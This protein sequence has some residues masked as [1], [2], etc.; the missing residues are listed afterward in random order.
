MPTNTPLSRSLE[1]HQ[2]SFKE[3]PVID[4]ASLVDDSN[5]ESVA[6][7]IGE[8]CE[9]VRFLY[10][11][12]HGISQYF[13]DEAYKQSAAFFDLPTEK[14]EQLHIR[15]SGETLRGYIPIYGENVD[16]GYTRDFKECF[17][18]GVGENFVSPFFGPILMPTIHP[19]FQST[20][21]NYHQA[22]LDLGRKQVRAIS[23][24]LNLPANN[25]ES[26]QRHPITIQRLLH[27]PPQS[28]EI[29]S[30]SSV[31]EHIPITVF[32]DN[33]GSGQ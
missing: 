4:V 25:F 18:L 1:S 32:F 13:I 16:P 5:P 20:L 3:I 15:N 6:R 33:L 7:I 14:K 2:T 26:R 11:K 28:S 24:S 17:D 31:S 8:T 21:E 19:D 23:I 12:K 27:H 22:M 9:Q 10:I 29:N 30:R